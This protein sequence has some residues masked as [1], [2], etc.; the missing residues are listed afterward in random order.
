M[1]DDPESIAETV[2]DLRLVAAPPHRRWRVLSW[3]GRAFMLAVVV[4]GLITIFDRIL[5]R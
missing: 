3:L 2:R 4:V 5:V 1:V